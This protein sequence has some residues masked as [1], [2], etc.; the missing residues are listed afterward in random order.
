MSYHMGDIVAGDI[1]GK[2]SMSYLRRSE[3][4]FNEY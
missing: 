3:K 4:K 1:V 2:F